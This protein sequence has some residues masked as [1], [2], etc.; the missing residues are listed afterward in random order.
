MLEHQDRN[1]SQRH[2]STFC[3]TFLYVDRSSITK[4]IEMISAD[5]FTNHVIIIHQGIEHDCNL[6]QNDYFNF[7]IECVQLFDE[8]IFVGA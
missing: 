3:R 1:N 7:I 8:P 6:Q 5:G 2:I 4:Q